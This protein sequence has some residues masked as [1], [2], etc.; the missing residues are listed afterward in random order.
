M[1]LRE[2]EKVATLASVVGSDEAEIEPGPEAEI[3]PGP[4]AEAAPTA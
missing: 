4:E 3:E 1:R 2:G